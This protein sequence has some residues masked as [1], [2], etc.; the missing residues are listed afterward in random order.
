VRATNGTACFVPARE[1]WG[2]ATLIAD[3]FPLERAARF[4]RELRRVGHYVRLMLFDRAITD[5][6]RV[7][8][9]SVSA[10]NPWGPALVLVVAA[11]F[12]AWAPRWAR[13]ASFGTIV[14]WV[15][16]ND[17]FAQ[18]LALQRE[19]RRVASD[20]FLVSDFVTREP[21]R[22]SQWAVEVFDALGSQAA[23]AAILPGAGDTRRYRARERLYTKQIGFR[24][25]T[26]VRIHDA[27]FT[28]LVH[29]L[30]QQAAASNTG[31]SR[32][33]TGPRLRRP[34]APEAGTG[35]RTAHARSGSAER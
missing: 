5:P 2:T 19:L 31:S 3:T 35:L 22:A 16:T 26:R 33:R 17:Q 11:G 28:I 30:R 1:L 29:D 32:E 20:A 7:A 25:A 8:V 18:R 13:W 14:A 15:A 4:P 9:V 6:E 21:G 23:V 34:S 12:L 27:A 24:V 10:T